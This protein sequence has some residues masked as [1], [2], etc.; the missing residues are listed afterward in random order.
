MSSKSPIKKKNAFLVKSSSKSNQKNESANSDETS[1]QQQPK[2][3]TSASSGA[4]E[5]LLTNPSETQGSKRLSKYKLFSNSKSVSK[6]SL[7]P[8]TETLLDSENPSQSNLTSLPPPL[9]KSHVTGIDSRM[10]LFTFI[11]AFCL[12]GWPGDK[13]F[14]ILL[15]VCL[16]TL[17]S[18]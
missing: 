5:S 8:T 16:Y 3:T 14:N 1:K 6:S 18:C 10:I 12:F 9:D 4:I 11:R 2:T 13:P 7:P 15:P 17:I